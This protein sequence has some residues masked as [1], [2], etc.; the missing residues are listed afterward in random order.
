VV[1]PDFLR[2]YRPDV[3]IIM[4]PIY[5]KEITLSLAEMGLYPQ[6]LL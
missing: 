2:E 6:I 4:N 1:G 5:E 3:V